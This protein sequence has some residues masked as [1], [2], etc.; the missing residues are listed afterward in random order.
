MPEGN[1]SKTSQLFAVAVA[2]AG[3]GVVATAAPAQA[4]DCGQWGF[5]G[6]NTLLRESTNES[7]TFSGNGAHINAPGT[8]TVSNGPTKQA[9]V[10]GDIDPGGH[11]TVNVNIKGLGTVNYVGDVGPNGQASGSS[12]PNGEVPWHSL[13]PMACAGPK[14]GPSISLDPGIGTLTINITD[15][16]GEAT[17]CQYSSDF[18][19]RSFDL[20]KN[21][22]ASLKVVPAV[23]LFIDHQVDIVCKNGAETH[24]SVFF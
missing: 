10:V 2:V 7:I 23:P 20:P 5:A 24:Q 15:H 3:A 8:W 14:E 21:G 1:F 13:A 22:T 17:T 19:N 6:S 16:A 9:T 11:M 4:A 12:D 18:V